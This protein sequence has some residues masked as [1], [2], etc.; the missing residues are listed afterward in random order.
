M[1]KDLPNVPKPT[2]PKPAPGQSGG[3]SPTRIEAISAKPNI[4]EQVINYYN[5]TQTANPDISEKFIAETRSDAS[6]EER[7]AFMAITGSEILQVVRNYEIDSNSDVLN[8][9]VLDS[10]EILN[11]FNPLSIIKLQNIDFNYFR[12][13]D[14]S[15]LDHEYSLDKTVGIATIS[16]PNN[17]ISSANK[18]QLQTFTPT[19]VYDDTIY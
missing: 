9:N 11:S 13:F 6:L 19:E 8:K 12:N 1:P 16:I 10:V 18:V 3:F 7:L 5:I 4:P 15:I 2:P 17:L 14:L